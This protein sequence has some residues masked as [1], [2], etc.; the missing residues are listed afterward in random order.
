MGRG[1][2]CWFV[3]ECIGVAAR[4]KG[5]TLDVQHQAYNLSLFS[6]VVYD[7]RM[8]LHLCGDV[9]FWVS[10]RS[11][12]TLHQ[13]INVEASLKA[14]PERVFIFDFFE[15]LTQCIQLIEKGMCI[16]A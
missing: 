14:D 1:D 9:F 12:S 13:F 15:N 3:Y 7:E 11:P 5:V 16:T 4:Q 6:C 2:R 8:G 10:A